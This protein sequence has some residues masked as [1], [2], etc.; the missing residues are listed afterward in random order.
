MK[1]F[2][3][4]IGLF[5]ILSTALL[6]AQE[7]KVDASKSSLKWIGKKVTGMHWGYVNIKDGQVQKKNNNFH[8]QFI[9]DMTSITNK[10]L[11]DKET[12]NKLIGHLKS[13]DFFSVAQHPEA[14][15]KIKSI[16]DY[17]PKKNQKGNMWVKGFLT[18]K[19]IT[20]E[21]GFP[22]EIKLDN[23][24]MTAKAEFNINR[25]KWDVRYGSGSFFDN[26][27]DKTIYD[28]I[29]FELNLV[30]NKN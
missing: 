25:A 27:G 6:S 18:I 3:G 19:N 11:D 13:E 4:I 29:E 9:I 10:D 16:T 12:N 5:V 2:F 28:D 20:H 17:K 15:F 24:M 23:N 1:R 26:L 21:I 8:G 22:A 14:T 30:A 7:Y